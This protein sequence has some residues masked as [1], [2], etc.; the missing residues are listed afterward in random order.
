MLIIFYVNGF[1]LSLISGKPFQMVI[2][3]L[4]DSLDFFYHKVEIFI[5]DNQ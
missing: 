5:W 4:Q 3:R 1:S 2:Y